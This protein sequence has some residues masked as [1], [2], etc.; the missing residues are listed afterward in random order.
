MSAG[1][2]VLIQSVQRICPRGV[3][4]Q[5]SISSDDPND[6]FI[7]IGGESFDSTFTGP[8]FES[9]LG[10]THGPA[11]DGT[12]EHYSS[13]D[14]F[15]E[16]PGGTYTLTVTTQNGRTG[17]ATFT[18][19]QMQ[20]SLALSADIAGA[21]VEQIDV[22]ICGT[23]S[24]ECA[25]HCETLL[26]VVWVDSEYNE[27]N[28]YLGTI[29]GAQFE[30]HMNPPRTAAGMRAVGHATDPFGVASPEAECQLVFPWP[31][32]PNHTGQ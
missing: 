11:P 26:Q 16:A 9:G 5:Y 24:D 10:F 32:D 30:L 28:A 23:V 15:D 7:L 19:Q 21:T 31:A 25:G 6:A 17:S 4:V 14:Q 18:L 3:G 12:H 27:T 1:L 13:S 8:G 20:P 29:P 22:K 2:N